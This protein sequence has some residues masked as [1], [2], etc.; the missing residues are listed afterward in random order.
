VDF[1]E[2]SRA[3]YGAGNAR[4]T[5]ATTI[6]PIPRAITES[7][8]IVAAS[9]SEWILPGEQHARLAHEYAPP[10]SRERERVDQEPPTVRLSTAHGSVM[11]S[12]AKH[13]SDARG[14]ISPLHSLKLAATK[15][16][17]RPSSPLYLAPHGGYV[18]W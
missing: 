16:A 15:V 2:C 12:K 13:P 5:P 7:I 6:P 17:D 4:L 18:S 3:G 9:V 8:R 11:L 1:Q 14:E 10:R